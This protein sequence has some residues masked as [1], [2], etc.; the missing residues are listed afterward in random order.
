MIMIKFSILNSQFS[1][2]QRALP[3]PRTNLG[4]FALIEPAAKWHLRNSVGA[5][6]GKY[7]TIADSIAPHRVVSTE[8]YAVDIA[9][10]IGMTRYAIFVQKRLNS[11]AVAHARCVARTSW[12]NSCRIFFFNAACGSAKI[13]TGCKVERT[14][15]NND[16]CDQNT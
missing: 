1:I 4:D 3:H 13:I 8:V 7:N 6:H 12:N 10:G 16:Q 2:I 11:L 9:T 14:N 5:L 15:T